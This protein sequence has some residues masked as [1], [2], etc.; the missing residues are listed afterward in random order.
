MIYQAKRSEKLIED[1]Q[2]VDESGNVAHVIQVELDADSVLTRITRKYTDLVKAM[3]EVTLMKKEDRE[4]MVES[5]MDRLRDLVTQLLEA[6]FGPED[7]AIILEFYERRYVEICREVI[8]FISKVILP[9]CLQLKKE[10][11]KS[12]LQSYDRKKA[13]KGLKG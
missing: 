3:S 10:N 2:L 12:I 1:F 5:A 8:P 4:E 6:T 7:A 13:R 9:R 11:Q